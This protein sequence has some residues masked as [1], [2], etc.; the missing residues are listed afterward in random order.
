VQNKLLAFLAVYHTP[1]QCEYD[2]HVVAMTAVDWLDVKSAIISVW[3]LSNLLRCNPP[4]ARALP[5]QVYEPLQLHGVAA[6][7]GYL[8]LL[9][10]I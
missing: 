5:I 1:K 2:M 4:L 7:C 3:S 6:N 10:G 8:A 9:H